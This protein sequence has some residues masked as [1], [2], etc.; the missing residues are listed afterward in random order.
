MTR[1]KKREGFEWGTL[2]ILGLPRGLPLNNLVNLVNSPMSLK[3]C[4]HWNNNIKLNHDI[5]LLKWGHYDLFSQFSRG[6][7]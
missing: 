3:T 5:P 2:G 4:F 6:K 1:E 7:K